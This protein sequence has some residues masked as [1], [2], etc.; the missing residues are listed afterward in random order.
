MRVH[1]ILLISL[2]FVA[3]AGSGASQSG[4]LGC[5]DLSK[6]AD[7]LVRLQLENWRSVSVDRIAS[8]WPSYLD[9]LACS[10]KNGCRL[11]G[12][13]NRIIA[14]HCECCETFNFDVDQNADGSRNEH[15]RNVII[16]Y[17]TRTEEQVVDTARKLARAAGLP[18]SQVAKI[19][20][21]PFER[22][23]WEENSGK[24]PRQSYILEMRINRSDSHWELDFSLSADSA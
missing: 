24:R 17:S 19:N 1:T 8:I 18:E 12:S 16:R 20:V 23:E 15:L 2:F 5:P 9:E 7:A 22:Y 14:G 4:L 11:V 13:K 10:S 6:I 3:G 21:G